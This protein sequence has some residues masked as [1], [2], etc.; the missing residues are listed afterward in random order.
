MKI[1]K[2]I[3]GLVEAISALEC[4]AQHDVSDCTRVADFLK[5]ILKE[6]VDDVAEHARIDSELREMRELLLDEQGNL[7]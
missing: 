7:K 2:I 6:L 4:A 1:D 3:E 5:E